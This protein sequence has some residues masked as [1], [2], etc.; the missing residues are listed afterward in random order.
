MTSR[1]SELTEAAWEIANKLADEYQQSR[2]V[3]LCGELPK[4]VSIAYEVLWRKYLSAIEYWP[5]E[6]VIDA[7]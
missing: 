6:N 7:D 2:P 4:A 1:E 3:S 5:T